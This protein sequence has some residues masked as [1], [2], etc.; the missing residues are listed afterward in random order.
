L[1]KKNIEKVL[2]LLS[3][4]P[5]LLIILLAILT[6]SYIYYDNQKNYEN[7][8]LQLKKDYLLKNR[9]E[10]Y[11]E[12]NK[13][14]KI[15]QSEYE[16]SEAL[17]QN[18]LK[19]RVDNAYSIIMGII[20][21]NK[22][23]SKSEKLKLIKDSLRDIRF[24]EGRG[25]YYI[26]S[27]S[28]ECILLP[29]QE[30]LEG[31]SFLEVKDVKGKYITKSII[32]SLKAG[33]DEFMKWWWYKPNNKSKQYEKLS[34]NKYIKELDIYV[35][36]GDYI[37]DLELSIKRR[38]LETISN[39]KYNDNNYFFIL[40]FKGDILLHENKKIL[41][42]NIYDFENIDR[43][44]LKEI[45]RIAKS[46]EGY[47]TYKSNFFNKFNE[48][49]FKTSYVKGFK[50]WGWVIATGFYKHDLQEQIN[51]KKVKLD[52]NNK[53]IILKIILISFF[54]TLVLILLLSY[55]VKF[56]KDRFTLIQNKM[57]KEIELN[58]EKDKLL[59]HQSKMASLGEML[60]NIA[61]QWR[62]PLSI[63][64]TVASGIKLNKEIG[65][66]LDDKYINDSVNTIMKSTNYLSKTIDDFRN[67]LRDDKCKVNFNIQDAI[68]DSLEIMDVKL[69]QQ[70]INIRI[71]LFEYEFFGLK[72]ELIQVLMNLISNS[73][74]AFGKNEEKYIFINMSFLNDN[75]LIS[76]FDNAGGIDD[77]IID[78]V[79][80]PYFTTKY[81][82][83]GTGIGL[84]MSE[85]IIT[86]HMDGSIFVKNELYNYE[87]KEFYGAKFTLNFAKKKAD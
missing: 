26:Y 8:L 19:N 37:L 74:D 65:N 85:Q 70:N 3:I 14:Y 32:T 59:F 44:N 40:N 36:T 52:T 48:Q 58:N 23:L 47:I 77:N 18:T 66:S 54:I 82:S 62:Q 50:K 57:K 20:N 64:S 78:R 9:L 15:V 34:Y 29:I 55:N 1:F 30:K 42:K 4:F 33:N 49:T 61:H 31:S 27:M 56:L 60:Q 67:F 28:G 84:Y 21:N 80:E 17:L 76:V 35:G 43:F 53:N 22:K 69:K 71:D 12:V 39:I 41:G 7:D 73:I 2:R 6:T 24:N 11:N 45:I 79:F 38:L 72:N 87:G 63:I 16:D 13:I 75:L 5:P 68:N 46:G 51:I 83:Q 10:A 25:Y 81:N 86:N